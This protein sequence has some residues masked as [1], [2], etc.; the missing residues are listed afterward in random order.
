MAALRSWWLPQHSVPGQGPSDICQLEG[1]EVC[2]ESPKVGCASSACPPRL[3]L[4][5]MFNGF[6]V[7]LPRLNHSLL[8]QA[9]D[10]SSRELGF[11]TS[12]GRVQCPVPLCSPCLAAART[13]GY[14]PPCIPRTSSRQDS[15]WAVIEWTT[16]TF[17]LH[18]MLLPSDLSQS[19]LKKRETISL[20]FNGFGVRLEIQTGFASEELGVWCINLYWGLNAIRF[21]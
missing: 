7:F 10:T 13:S 11:H 8:Q 19:C 14:L 6:R 12:T 9:W 1:V 17:S 21:L 5:R 15:K 16:L 18:W 20:K 2:H 4:R 3:K